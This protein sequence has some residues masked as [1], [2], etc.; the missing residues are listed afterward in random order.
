MDRKKIGEE[1]M[2]L[3]IYANCP[4]DEDPQT[5]ETIFVKM[6]QDHARVVTIRQDDVDGDT[7]LAYR[8]ILRLYNLMIKQTRKELRGE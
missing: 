3:C 8:A 7:Y 6:Q 2:K 1:L 5:A 4:M